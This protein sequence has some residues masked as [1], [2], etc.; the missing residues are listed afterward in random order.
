MD[1]AVV[2]AFNQEKALVRAFSVI[3]NLSSTWHTLWLEA[4]PGDEGV[5]ILSADLGVSE[6]EAGDTTCI[7]GPCYNC[8]WD[9]ASNDHNQSAVWLSKI[10][11]LADAFNKEKVLQP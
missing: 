8:Q 6:E 3:M 10:L 11:Y 2:A 9:L 1:T 4:A 5:R 7:W